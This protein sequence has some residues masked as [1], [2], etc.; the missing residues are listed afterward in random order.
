MELEKSIS[1]QTDKYLYKY[2]VSLGWFCG[3]ASSL[4]RLGLRSTSGPFDWYFSDFASV[5]QVIHTH[6]SDF[7]LK[8]NLMLESDE[9]FTDKKYGFVYPHDLQS[10]LEKE[11]DAIYEKYKRRSER[12]LEMIKSPTL[13]FRAVRDERE[14][15]YINSN[16]VCINSVLKEFNEKNEVVYLTILGMP[17]LCED[18]NS[19]RLDI[20]EYEYNTFG[21]RH[22]FENSDLLVKYCRSLLDPD[23]VRHNL[24]VD[25]SNNAQKATAAYV[26]FL[27]ENNEN[28]IE[29]KILS[30]FRITQDDTL[31]IWG[32]GK[33]GT[34]LAYYLEQRGIIVKAII[35]SNKVGFID[36]HF[37]IKAFSDLEED[38]NVF[39]AIASQK[40]VDDIKENVE[41]DN[42]NIKCLSYVDIYKDWVDC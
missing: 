14:V 8:E 18:V 30:E 17:E 6:F 11:Y 29:E 40:A 42:R 41:K 38:S 34:E 15:E 27:I 9:V 3:T 36:N 39:I 26:H 21:M 35:D 4:S 1:S 23:I 33:Y 20:E 12:F 22:L 7:L 32:A 24:I 37:P 16:W 31:Y 2:C 19:Y 25:Y 28:G 5:I 10:D 13:F